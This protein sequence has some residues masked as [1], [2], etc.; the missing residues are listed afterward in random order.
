MHSQ[1]VFGNFFST[2]PLLD[3]LRRK[4]HWREWAV[5]TVLHLRWRAMDQGGIDVAERIRCIEVLSPLMDANLMG[6]A[7]FKPSTSGEARAVM[8][9]VAL[10]LLCVYS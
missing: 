8:S 10:N 2:R 3:R 6:A 5:M 9:R 1:A 4:G 7:M